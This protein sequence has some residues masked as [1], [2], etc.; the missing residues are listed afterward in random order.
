MGNNLTAGANER[1]RHNTK[2][3]DFTDFLTQKSTPLSTSGLSIYRVTLEVEY[4]GGVDLDLPGEL[5]KSKYKP[6]YST[7][8]HLEA[9]L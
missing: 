4:L 3:R 2:A 6:R 9:S 5:P 7:T 1:R 8:S